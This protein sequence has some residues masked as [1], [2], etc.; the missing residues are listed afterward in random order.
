[1]NYREDDTDADE[2]TKDNADEE[3]QA[4]RKKARVAG[5]DDEKTTGRS[6]ALVLVLCLTTS[7]VV[8]ALLPRDDDGDQEWEGES[9]LCSRTTRS[10]VAQTVT[11]M[12][13]RE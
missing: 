10:D 6:L 3:E 13:K 11:T 2:D 9:A 12:K 8:S 7:R 4:P 5:W 1:M